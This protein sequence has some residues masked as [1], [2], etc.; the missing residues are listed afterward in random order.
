MSC[1]LE[2]S[3]TR[4][5]GNSLFMIN[6]GDD[7]DDENHNHDGDDEDDIDDDDDDDAPTWCQLR[8]LIVVKVAP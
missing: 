4:R 7:D 5:P 3:T 8:P 6:Q 2:A 1:L